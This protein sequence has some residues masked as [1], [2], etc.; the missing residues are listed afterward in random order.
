MGEMMMKTCHYVLCAN[1]A[2]NNCTITTEKQ[3]I[4]RYSTAL[5][6]SCAVMF[7]VG[8]EM[9]HYVKNVALSSMETMSILSPSPSS[10]EIF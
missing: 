3:Q 8:L 4:L 1:T 2:H 10:S 6:T 7:G 9:A 5:L